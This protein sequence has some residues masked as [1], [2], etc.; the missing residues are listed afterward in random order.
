MITSTFRCLND[1]ARRGSRRDWHSWR[2]ISQL[3]ACRWIK[4]RADFFHG[5][6]PVFDL[7]H[8]DA[9]LSVSAAE[10]PDLEALCHLHTQSW[11][12]AYAPFL[13]HEALARLSDHMANR[14]ATLPRGIICAR[15]AEGL[16]GFIRIKQRQGW[17]YIDNLHTR[18]DLR[19]Q[20]IGGALMMAAMADL[21]MTGEGRVWLT[22]IAANIKARRF[23]ARFGGIDATPMIEDVLGHNIAT[24]AVVWNRL[25]VAD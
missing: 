21:R 23:Y 13:P 11:A 14:W 6:E 25:L 17:P 15:N 3:C 7:L 8:I 1:K 16:A 19:G 24:R 20:G 4:R 22:V 5:V 10:P 12:S 18:P 2:D 9:M